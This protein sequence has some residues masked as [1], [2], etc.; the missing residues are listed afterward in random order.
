[1]T[2][3]GFR[4]GIGGIVHETNTYA[5]ETFGPTGLDAFHA[6]AGE[7]LVRNH[8]GTRSCIG[9][10]LDAADELGAE[11]VPLWWAAAEPSGTIERSAYEAMRDQLVT[12]I[13]SALPLDALALDLHGAGVMGEADDLEADLGRAIRNVVGPDLPIVVTLDLHGNIS[14]EMAELYDVML[15]YHLYPHTDMWERGDESLRLLPALLDGSLHPT[16]HVEHL[17]ILLPTS[18]TDPGYPAAEMNEVC[19]RL[20][21]RPGVVD[22]TVFHGFPFTDIENVGVHVVV[23]TDGDAELAR[24]VGA[25]VGGWV[26]SNRER[27]RLE[28]PTPDQAVRLA[29]A[30]DTTGGPVVINETSDNPGGG[31]PGDGTHLLRAL[32]EAEPGVPVVFG[33]LCDPDVAG[34]AHRAG[35]GAT[36]DVRLGGKHDELHGLPVEATV[37]VKA[38]TDGR[39]TLRAI[40]EGTRVNLGRS[41]RLVVGGRSG[42]VQVIVVSHRSQTFDEQ[43]FLL[44]GIDVTRYAVVALKSSN[45][46]RAGFRDVASQIIT[47]DAPGL[48]TNRVEVFPHTRASRPLWPQDPAATYP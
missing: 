4:V 25:E 27:F 15:G 16:A 10:M 32:L 48:T 46:F 39:F 43:V 42:A 28:S 6:T 21:E 3:G 24:A 18:T 12:A 29:L 34:A 2:P 31:T 1:M 7:R 38:L 22:V 26:W 5:T 23:T 19:R 20:E 14:D 47:A 44:H 13:R 30:A 40:S 33:F 11:V 9:G 17:P 8:R 45:H 35:V 37:Y 36:I 41:A